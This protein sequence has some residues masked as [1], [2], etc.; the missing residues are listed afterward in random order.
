[1]QTYSCQNI[2]LKQ[3]ALCQY[4]LKSGE[5]RKYFRGKIFFE[6]SDKKTGSA[7]VASVR[8]SVQAS[9]AVGWS[10]Q[11]IGLCHISNCILSCYFSFCH[12]IICYIIISLFIISWII[13]LYQVIHWIILWGLRT[14]TAFSA[15]SF[16]STWVL[17]FCIDALTTIAHWLSNINIHCCNYDKKHIITFT[18]S[19][20]WR[21]HT[22]CPRKKASFWNH[23]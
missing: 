1:M 11:V 5:G 15:V 9:A 2:L 22:G 17:S 14:I 10:R 19:S 21:I 18:L 12:I 6:K 20:A 8:D 16:A 7:A 4:F 23:K 3:R 13:M